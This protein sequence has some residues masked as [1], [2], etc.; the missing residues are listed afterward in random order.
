MSTFMGIKAGDRVTFMANSGLRL[1]NG[2]AIPER[3]Q[4]QGRACALLLFAGHV[5]VNTGGRHGT[6][7]V[8][9]A[10]NYVRHTSR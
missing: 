2:K 8:V 3:R 5:V 4:M 9:D 10:G 1:V 7:H 6:P